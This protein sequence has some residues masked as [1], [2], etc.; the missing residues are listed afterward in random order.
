MN[1]I[2]E[3]LA[4]NSIKATQ[5]QHHC[6]LI[7]QQADGSLGIVKTAGLE[8]RQ[9]LLA[10]AGPRFRESLCRVRVTRRG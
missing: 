8:Q 1:K 5:L 4:Q 6:G 9:L 10:S 2:L 3:P 7:S